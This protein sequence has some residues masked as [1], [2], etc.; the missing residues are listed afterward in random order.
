MA[1]AALRAPGPLICQSPTPS[2]ST[3]GTYGGLYPFPSGETNTA[4]LPVKY[5]QRSGGGAGCS[6]ISRSPS[7]T[8]RRVKLGEIQKNRGR[9]LS[10]QWSQSPKGTWSGW[11]WWPQGNWMGL[12]G[13]GN[14]PQAP[15][16]PPR[17]TRVPHP[18][19]LPGK[20]W[21]EGAGGD[22][23]VSRPCPARA[24]GNC[25]RTPPTAG[26]TKRSEGASGQG[27][28]GRPETE[29]DLAEPQSCTA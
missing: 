4:A 11:S 27:P 20:R 15:E 28:S 17:P 29:A 8:L 24:A 21:G 25:A 9:E 10:A 6:G 14:H 12:G 2:L 13:G 26:G 23:P 7:G 22:S 5:L 18:G 16:L 3:S 19:R 1:A